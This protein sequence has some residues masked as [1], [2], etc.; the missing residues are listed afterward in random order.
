MAFIASTIQKN[1]HLVSIVPDGPTTGRWFGD[2]AEAAAAWA[3]AAN[4]RAANCYWTVNVCRPGVNRK[5]TKADIVA[6]RFVHLDIDP[7]K[8]GSAFDKE[9]A[10]QAL[11][12]AP[13][14]PTAALESGGG[15]QAFWRHDGGA[16]PSQIEA[17]NRAL[18]VRFGG[19]PVANIDR[20]MRLP[21]T[22]NWPDAK[23][24]AR[25]RVP[26][27]AQII[28]PDTGE[29]Y[30][31]EVLAR[32]YP[33][34]AAPAPAARGDVEID[35]ASVTPITADDL[36]LGATDGLRFLIEKPKG[37]DRSKDT[38]RFAIEALK[39]GL[40]PEQV[41]G[42]LICGANAVSAHCLDAEKDDRA[43][44]RAAQRAIDRAWA[45]TEAIRSL[46]RPAA[47]GGV[48]DDNAPVARHWTLEQMLQECVFVADGSR[49]AQ[50]DRPR[51]ALP[52]ADF[53]NLTAASKMP[54]VVGGRG[55][56]ERLIQAQVSEQWLKDPRRLGVETLTF[57]PAGS[58]F[59]ENP[60]GKPA[61]NTWVGFP[62]HNPPSYW[63]ER[64]AP[65]A[66]HLSWL[67]GADTSAFLDWLAHLAQCPGTMP[68]FGFLHIAPA[69]GL[70]RGW[71][72]EVLEKVFGGKHVATGFDLVGALRS[73][74]N[75][76]LGG[77]LLAVVDEIDAGGG[78]WSV[79][80][81]LK[82]IVTETTRT[83]NAKYGRMTQEHNACRWLVFSNSE[84]ALPLESSDRRFH[85]SRCDD[86][87]KATAYYERLYTLRDDP[88]FIA[89][90]AE[91]LRRRDIS[92]FRPGET[93]PMTAAK[94]GLVERI[95][96][97]NESLLHD[98]VARWPTDLIAYCEIIDQIGHGVGV[99]GR[100]LAHDL[101]RAGLRKVG[102]I[103]HRG[104]ATSVYAVRNPERWAGV[105]PSA[106]RAEIN[107]KSSEAKE[108]TLYSGDRPPADD[109]FFE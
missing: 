20:V 31:A 74:F 28:Q 57:N 39:H 18:E 1:I 10:A 90:V 96:S 60:E 12:D 16:E 35:W 34:I 93:P 40:S 86:Q 77:K 100:S 82:K 58:V 27:L 109:G 8:D 30:S 23:K 36:S 51:C 26:A 83:V 2:D 63:A 14:A 38:L 92:K 49:V 3:C 95:R 13:V 72:S 5:P 55:E 22:V 97:D 24:R 70:G 37:L 106:A 73:G 4:A 85:V 84:T 41:A 94:R 102:R 71:I 47:D 56:C 15:L 105:S 6:T 64:C 104:N 17:L 87:P 107:R 59:T 53:K 32:A 62:T 43:T 66:E 9:A 33:P 91:F 44:R 67:F 98:I 79:A 101:D 48:D 46:T 7:P 45:E 42:V 81:S 103:K 75:G 80:Q 108:A 54:I 65:F 89:S 99:N 61:L 11:I 25:G 88:Q 29:V 21:G 68:T 52:W 19:D 50:I 78:Q 76:E 69:Q